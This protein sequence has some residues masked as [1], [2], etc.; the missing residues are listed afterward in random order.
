MAQVFSRNEGPVPG[1]GDGES[2]EREKSPTSCCLLH[3]KWLDLCCYKKGVRSYHGGM[4]G[5][6][7]CPVGPS[8]WGQT[9]D[10][11]ACH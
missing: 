1:G 4:G 3:F 5:V 11:Q 10:S 2:P 8:K 6:T 7:P 9:Q